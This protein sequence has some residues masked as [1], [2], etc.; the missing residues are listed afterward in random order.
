[1][2]DRR[3]PVVR[4]CSPRPWAKSK[5]RPQR[6]RPPGVTCPRACRRCRVWQRAAAGLNP[7]SV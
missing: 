6:P 2:S 1:M 5:G 7:A 3:F 4:R